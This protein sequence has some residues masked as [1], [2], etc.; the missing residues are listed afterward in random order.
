M[1][2][3]KYNSFYVGQSSTERIVAVQT[4]LVNMLKFQF[5]WCCLESGSDQI[6]WVADELTAR[7]ADNTTCEKNNSGWFRVRTLPA[8]V[9]AL[10]SL[11]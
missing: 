6:E 2:L 11:K 10:Q 5:T 8:H 4:E 9:F 7:A 3:N 1:D